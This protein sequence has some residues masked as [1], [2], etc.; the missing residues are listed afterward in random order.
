MGRIGSCIPRQFIAVALAPHCW[1][2]TS[3]ADPEYV[4]DWGLPNAFCALA[5]TVLVSCAIALPHRN[6]KQIATRGSFFTTVA[7][8][9]M[10]CR[11]RPCFGNRPAMPLTKRRLYS[12]G[13][14]AGGRFRLGAAAGGPS[15]RQRNRGCLSQPSRAII[16]LN[17]LSAELSANR[18][19]APP[20]EP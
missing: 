2:E 3:F 16:S 17:E 1:N 14:G 11:R 13:Q 7:P 8:P 6:A 18:A 9:Y 19:A 20:P 10:R 5:T 12:D 15:S 4:M